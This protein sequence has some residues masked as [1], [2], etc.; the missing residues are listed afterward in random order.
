MLDSHDKSKVLGIVKKLIDDL[1]FRNFELL[2]QVWNT[3]WTTFPEHRLLHW[4]KLYT[5]YGASPAF[6]LQA[7]CKQGMDSSF[8]IVALEPFIVVVFVPHHNVVSGLD[9]NI[10]LIFVFYFNTVVTST[11][12]ERSH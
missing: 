9:S 6:S 3:L 7:F 8:A 2:L 12:I 10:F 11:Q 5:F 4:I 1:E